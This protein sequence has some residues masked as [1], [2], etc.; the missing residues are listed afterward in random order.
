MSRED[1]AKNLPQR[2]YRNEPTAKNLPQGTYCKEITAKNLLQ[3]LA[4][5]GIL[6]LLMTKNL[7]PSN[8]L[9]FCV[10]AS[11]AFGLIAGIFLMGYGLVAIPR[12]L[13]RTADNKNYRK[14]LFHRAGVQAEKALSAHA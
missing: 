7:A 12:Q 11:N 9:G 10:A 6:L 2:T 5:S 13:W 14:L 8:I 1:R 4:V 3:A